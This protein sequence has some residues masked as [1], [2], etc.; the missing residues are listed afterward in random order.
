MSPNLS[1]NQNLDGHSNIV[2][3]A[4]W[5]ECCQKLTTC[6]SNGLI[7]V[8]LTQS[9]NWYEEMINK[10]NK[11][12]VVGMAW[13]HNGSKIAIA[14]E[15]G[16]AIVGSVDGNRLWNKNVASNLVTLCIIFVCF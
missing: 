16:Q 14:Y 3:I 7:I 11:S 1:M 13:S 8:W 6:D 2:H 4:E 12:V 9:D 15:D 10:R 5:N